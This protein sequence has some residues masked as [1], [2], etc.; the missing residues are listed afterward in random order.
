MAFCT[1]AALLGGSV[2]VGLEDSLY[3]GKGSSPRPTPSKSAR[4]GASSRN[5]VMRLRRRRRPAKC[6]LSRAAIESDS[7]NWAYVRRC[8]GCRFESN[9]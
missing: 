1:Q 3:I 7:E 2:R 4:S 8:L 5:W 6:W 9:C